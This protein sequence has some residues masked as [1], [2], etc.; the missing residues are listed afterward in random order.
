MLLVSRGCYYG[1]VIKELLLHQLISINLTLLVW[2]NDC[3]YHCLQTNHD[4]G[5]KFR[6]V[7]SQSPAQALFQNFSIF[8]IKILVSEFNHI[9][10][11]YEPISPPGAKIEAFRQSPIVCF[12]KKIKSSPFIVSQSKYF[13]YIFI[14]SLFF[15]IIFI[16]SNP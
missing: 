7:E 5:Q 8:L 4:I 13:K 2:P 10:K 11:F 16:D 12:N 6:P 9:L 3:L 1:V 15:F 14:K